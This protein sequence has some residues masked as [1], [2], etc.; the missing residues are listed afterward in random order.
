MSRNRPG[1]SVVTIRRGERITADYLNRTRNPVPADLTD[2]E[3]ERP[4]GE[5]S[6]A[7]G[8]PGSESYTAVSATFTVVRVEDENDPEIYIEQDRIDSITFTENTS[9]KTLVLDMTPIYT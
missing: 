9:G 1:Q 5:D 4:L 7:P 8:E 6:E 3:L 2:A